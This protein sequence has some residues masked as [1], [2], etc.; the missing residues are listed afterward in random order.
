MQPCFGFGAICWSEVKRGETK[1]CAF[2]VNNPLV[3]VNHKPSPIKLSNLPGLRVMDDNVALGRTSKQA[4]VG[5][6]GTADCGEDAIL[7]L[8]DKSF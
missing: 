3:E 5:S 1:T 6:A 4:R 7:G 8:V 2:Q